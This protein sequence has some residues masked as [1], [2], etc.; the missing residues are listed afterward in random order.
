ML[1]SVGHSAFSFARASFLMSSRRSRKRFFQNTNLS[2]SSLLGGGQD[3]ST[4]NNHIPHLLLCVS[5]YEDVIF[6]WFL[7]KKECDPDPCFLH[8]VFLEG[9]P[10]EAEL[11]LRIR[12]PIHSLQL[13]SYNLHKK[14]KMLGNI[15]VIAKMI[16]FPSLNLC[17][18][19]RKCYL[20]G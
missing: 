1:N 10:E 5:S 2:G 11:G 3:M 12:L 18:S 17:S 6:C 13:V 14:E 9:H 16:K 7:F 15:F 8:Q 4:S 20:L 19:R